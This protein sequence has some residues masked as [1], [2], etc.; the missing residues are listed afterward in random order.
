[1]ADSDDAAVGPYSGDGTGE[2]GSYAAAD[3]EAAL[4]ATAYQGTV[5]NGSMPCQECGQLVNP[6]IVMFLGSICPD[7]QTRRGA[8]HVKK[9]TG[10]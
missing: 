3:R 4:D 8:Q 5:Y 6:A 10:R 2:D 1:M 7:C 9:L